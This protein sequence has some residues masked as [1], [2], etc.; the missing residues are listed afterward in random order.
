MYKL[1][2]VT[3]LTTTEDKTTGE[4]L[5]K[6][7]GRDTDGNRHRATIE[8]TEPYAFAPENE[9]TPDRDYITNVEFGYTGYDGTPLKKIATRLPQHVNRKKGD[10]LADHFTT[11]YE[12][13][14]PFVRRVSI[15]YGLSGYIRIPKG[16]RV[17]IHDIETEIDASEVPDIK[18]RV[19]M[20][21]IEVDPPTLTERHTFQDFVDEASQP[22]TAITTYD[23]YTEEYLLIVLDPDGQVDPGRIRHYLEDHWEDHELADRFC[24]ADMRMVQCDTE[25]AV[26]DTF[27]SEIKSCRPDVISGWN[28]VK[29]D[30][31]YLM[32][33]LRHD[34]MA[35]V[36]EHRLSDIGAVSGYKTAQMIDGLPGFDLMEAFCGK[37]SFSEW[38][39]QRLDYVANEE[40]E[41]GK[42]GDVNIGEEYRQNRSRFAAYNIIDTQLLVGLEQKQGIHEFFYL[43]A[44]LS[45]IQIYDTFSEMRIVD[46]F[47]MSRR[48]DDEIL[49]SMDEKELDEIAGGLVLPPS[50]GVHEWVAVFDVK[51]LYPSMFITLN[52]S[53]E[54]LTTDPAEADIICPGMPESADDV[55]GE[56]TAEHIEWDVSGG[57]ALGLKADHEGLLPK[58]LKLLFD[59]RDEFK[60][61]R[62]T[63]DPESDAYS[64]WDAKQ[65]A[66]KVIMNSFYGVSQN[67]WY[68]LSTPIRESQGVGSSITAGGRYTVWSGAKIAE[69]MGFEVRYGDTDSIFISLA[70]PDEDPDDLAPEEVVR[71]GK[72]IEQRLNERM[73]DVADA[74]GIDEAHPFLADADLHG[75]DRHCISWEFE[76]LYRR[77]FQAGKKKRYAGLPTWKEGKWHVDPE[78]GA[79]DVDPDITG[80]ESKRADV[81]EVTETIQKT[82]MERVLDGQG[83]EDLSAYLTTEIED[84]REMRKPV[85]E[86]AYPGT[87]KKPLDHYANTQTARACRYSIKYLDYEWREGD[88]PWVYPVNGTPPM[89]PDTD[90]I[91]LEWGEEV[92]DGFAVDTEEIIEKKVRSPLDPILGTTGWTFEE[93]Y[94]GRQVQGMD[95]G[96]GSNP[97]AGA[98]FVNT[99]TEQSDDASGDA[100]EDAAGESASATNTLSW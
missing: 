1:I 23:T 46:G 77:F 30:H 96:G 35:D 93:L 60:R 47:V 80:F 27:I 99:G 66:I 13:D 98:D 17:S 69:D 79:G 70:Y 8:G 71:R 74:F 87:L 63:H 7:A 58:Y 91:A 55:G 54:A 61:I 36:N 20:A 59:R 25:Q 89:M 86:I 26:L 90:V 32:N 16:R 45:G 31:E 12:G 83:F 56:I 67:K 44:D 40:L 62:N 41:I 81:P 85:W 53:E 11:L 92:P 14:I 48:G 5:V 43:V 82:I 29:F 64:V 52:V 88:D 49:P 95:L 51:S 28:W 4:V 19:M 21:D 75:N 73:D 15:D 6:L 24:E 94:T 84:I 18:P 57:K 37:M 68:R 34:D 9:P 78:T 65:A 76:K 38:R 50:D 100:T 33:R 97:F 10:S 39:S 22:I 2:R 3:D 72:E 42:V